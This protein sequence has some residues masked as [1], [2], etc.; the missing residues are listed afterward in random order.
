MQN[1][2]V[3]TNDLEMYVKLLF[4]QWNYKIIDSN[5]LPVNEI[6]LGKV[7]LYIYKINQ[8]VIENINLVAN[9]DKINMIKSKL[10]TGLVLIMG[11]VIPVYIDVMYKL[12]YNSQYT[13]TTIKNNID[14]L[15]VNYINSGK[16]LNKTLLKQ[17]VVQENI[18][19]MIDFDIVSIS[20]NSFYD[21]FTN[22]TLLKTHKVIDLNSNVMAQIGFKCNY[23][24]VIYNLEN[25]V[26]LAQVGYPMVIGSNT[27]LGYLYKF[28]PST[29]I[30]GVNVSG[31]DAVFIYEHKYNKTINDVINEA[32]SGGKNYVTINE[33]QSSINISNK[34]NLFFKMLYDVDLNEVEIGIHNM[35][36]TLLSSLDL[37]TSTNVG[38]LTSIVE[39]LDIWK[40]GY[41]L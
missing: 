24:G 9:A 16:S 22:G 5:S 15:I 28:K 27:Q 12:E 37:V 34:T 20:Y 32:V 41:H 33:L 30:E 40:N 13:Y 29:S 35:D 8:D 4:P 1:R 39:A 19:G 21:T 18:G 6:Q 2:I 3:E 31:Q 11:A 7:F 26:D 25:M 17:I 38:R 10:R 14:Q 36:N 23:D